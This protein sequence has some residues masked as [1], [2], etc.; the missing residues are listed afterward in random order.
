MEANYPEYT[1]LDTVYEGAEVVEARNKVEGYIRANPDMVAGYGNTGGSVLSWSSAKEL[2]GRDDILA[3]GYDYTKQNL[4]IVAEG[5]AVALV[6]QPLYEEGYMALEL[7]DELL[8]GKIFNTNEA[9]WYKKLD[10]PLVY[11]GG[12]GAHGVAR[13]YDYFSRSE[14]RFGTSSNY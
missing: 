9:L 2:T 13:Y 3:V 5:G 8:N 1:I 11:P 10:A 6:A 12:E 7:I 14:A 4:D